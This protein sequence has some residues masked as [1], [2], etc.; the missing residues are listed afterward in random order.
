MKLYQRSSSKDTRLL[1]KQH[2][3][4]QQE[5]DAQEAAREGLVLASELEMATLG[6]G[7]AEA[8]QT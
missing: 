3:K 6:C 2:A 7:A 8:I 1:R 5:E 4:R